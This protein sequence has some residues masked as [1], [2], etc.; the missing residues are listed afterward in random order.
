VTAH[1]K[2][3]LMYCG[4]VLALLVLGLIGWWRA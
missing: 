3:W 4:M 2:L 1:E